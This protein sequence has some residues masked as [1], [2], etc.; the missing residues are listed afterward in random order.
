[1]QSGP[2][3]VQA[4]S[5]LVSLVRIAAASVARRMH[6]I[7]LLP[8]LAFGLSN[9]AFK[10][11][12]FSTKQV[13][14]GAIPQR[15]SLAS[16]LVLVRQDLLLAGILVPVLA[17]CVTLLLSD[18]WQRA[19]SG[20]LAVALQ[21]MLASEMVAYHAVGMFMPLD[22]I[23]RLWHWVLTSHDASLLSLPTT[24][25]YEAALWTSIV[26]LLALVSI[27][28]P[29]LPSSKANSVAMVAFA[30]LA[31]ATAAAWVPR[32]RA[33]EMSVPVLQMANRGLWEH[34]EAETWLG[35][36]QSLP[37]LLK[38]YRLSSHIPAPE[39]SHYFG[40]ARG[41]NVLF[42]VMESMPAEVVDPA[43]DPLRDMPNLAAL[44]RHAFVTTA[45]YTPYPLTNRAVFAMFTSM[46]I[47]NSAGEMVRDEPVATPG[48]VRALNAERYESAYYG[49]VW[50]DQSERDDRLLSS[51]G[52]SKTVE[53]TYAG[54]RTGGA[55]ES[56]DGDVKVVQAADLQV[57]RKLRNDLH[58]W[59]TRKQ[60]FLAA[61]LPQVGH[62]PWRELAPAQQHTSEQ[63]GRAL[64]ALQ[65]AWLGLLIQD[66][67]SEGLLDHTI[68]V[69]TSD[70]GVRREIAN[71]GESPRNIS[72]GRLEDCS[73]RV[74]LMI[75]V[76]RVLERTVLI[77]AA[78]SHLDVQPTILDL[79]GVNKSR[80]LEQGMALW[81]SQLA[82]RRLFLGTLG[83]EGYCCDGVYYMKN[84]FGSISKSTTLHFNA[85]ARLDGESEEARSVQRTLTEHRMQEHAI[86]ERVLKNPA[87]R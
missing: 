52:F 2:D 77:R 30:L 44:R 68:I 76:P 25:W 79:L 1:M 7:V 43:T 62:D 24:A 28:Y 6:G 10:L 59:A 23:R 87:A 26:L 40:A 47:Q 57:L 80:D 78:S 12:V 65:D 74:P 69:F 75:F 5:R 64:V 19:T 29:T 48:I 34:E 71:S 85:T 16:R 32:A 15:L 55:Y 21:L 41:Y 60:P 66:L 22:A 53:P 20:T 36:D 72:F 18:G 8:W 86:L 50:K 81:N 83:A 56:F 82:T 33:D 63:R 13:L 37:G 46:Y 54:S 42:F 58:T 49:F 70:H 39:R 4:H 17:W 45:N 35:G 84:E 67:K 38:Q 61:F 27:R 14:D 73:M 31:A 11:S 3:T 9:I 51:L